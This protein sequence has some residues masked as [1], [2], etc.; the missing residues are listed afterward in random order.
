VKQKEIKIGEIM[1]RE[2]MA[3]LQ[4]IAKIEDIPNKDRIKYISFKETSWK[5]IGGNS[6]KIGQ[7][8]VYCETDSILTEDFLSKLSETAST[9]LKKRCYVPKYNGCV[10]RCMKMAGTVSY[11]I[12]F[13]E[14][15]LSNFFT[16]EEFD[17]LKIE[18]DLT[19]KLFIKSKDDEVPSV[20]LKQQSWFRRVLKHLLWK[21][22]KIREKSSTEWPPFIARTDETRFQNLYGV[23]FNG[24]NEGKDFYVTNKMDGCSIT[25]A[26][27]KDRFYIL[28]RNVI[29]YNQ[30]IKKA[31]SQLN[32]KKSI[33]QQK[34]GSKYTE[35]A[36]KYDIPKIMKN[37]QKYYSFFRTKS[38]KNFAI[39][40]ELCGPAIQKNRIGL[41]E[42]D[43]FVFN[44]YD[45]D[46]SKYYSWDLIKNLC[47]FSQLKTVPLFE[48]TTWKWNKPEDF[49]EYAKQAKYGNKAGE[50]FV[51][52]RYV[53]GADPM[54]RPD[55]GMAN[56]Y[57]FK[58]INSEYLLEEKD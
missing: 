40:A 43:F 48:K 5:V 30:P 28:S 14:N 55:R 34:I 13:D 24:E 16:K 46:E 3:Y 42:L 4:T 47:C 35:A 41:K 53:T 23:L 52:R 49:E 33:I 2:R 25:F 54:P 10:I 22:F 9:N 12:I 44:V 7:K 18:D 26:L 56:I 20:V 19:N 15:D 11:G 32:S 38:F 36:C 29:I 39:Q 21:M 1:P 50:G 6:L 27:N 51:I 31:I 8:V 17:R 58:C 37:I 57:S 45:I